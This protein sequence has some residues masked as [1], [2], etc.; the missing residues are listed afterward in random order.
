MSLCYEN[1]GE[2]CGV[3]GCGCTGMGV[4]VFPVV[5]VWERVCMWSDGDY[6]S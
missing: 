1:K 5:W 4:G 6:E 3:D 2:G